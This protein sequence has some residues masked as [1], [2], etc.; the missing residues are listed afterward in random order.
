MSFSGVAL[1]P[2]HIDKRETS[3][4]IF[5]PSI[6][7]FGAGGSD[8]LIKLG[9]LDTFCVLID[10]LGIMFSPEIGANH[11]SFAPLS[12]HLIIMNH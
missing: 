9:A 6:I 4:S 8:R 3:V 12:Y 10:S 2:V 7:N 1:S 5:L 11:L